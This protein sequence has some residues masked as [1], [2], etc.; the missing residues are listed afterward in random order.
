MQ[1][2]AADSRGTSLPSLWKI[3]DGKC[4]IIGSCCEKARMLVLVT[5]FAAWVS[6]TN[7]M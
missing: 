7:S 2:I 3:L 4:L 6:V 5:P 1:I